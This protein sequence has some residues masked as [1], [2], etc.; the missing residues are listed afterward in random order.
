MPVRASIFFNGHMS[1]QTARCNPGALAR[2]LDRLLRPTSVAVVGISAQP[3]TPG[4]TVLSNLEAAGFSGTLHRVSRGRSEVAGRP[5]VSSIGELPEHVDLA[6]LCLPQNAV[7]QALLDCAQRRVG[8]VVVFASG[9]AERDD[10]G[11]A[12]QDELA[13]IATENQVA[14]LG[15]NCYG[16]HSHAHALPISFSRIAPPKTALARTVAIVSQSGGMGAAMSRN[17]QVQGVGATYMVAT[18]NE[19]TLSVEDFIADFVDDAETRVIAVLAEHLRQPQLLLSAA[20]RARAAGKAI[21][22]LH[23]GRSQNARESALSHTGALAGDHALMRALVS[24]EAVILVD[25]FQE[26]VDVASV[27]A[28]YPKAPTAG[29]GVLTTSGAFRGLTFD[30]CEQLGLD[31]PALAPSTLR[32]LREVLPGFTDAANP[33]DLT[34]Q[35]IWQRDLLGAAAA[36]LL[37]DDGIGSIVIALTAAPGEGSLVNAQL[38][39]PVLRESTKPVLYA[40]MTDLDV[41]H[42]QL[43]PTL[44]E[45]GVPYF[46]SPEAALA[47]I[48]RITAHG[49]ARLRATQRTRS[50]APVPTLPRD[51]TLNEAEAKAWLAQAGIAMPQGGLAADLLQA[52]ALAERIGYPLALKA[53]SRALLHK[54]DAG[55]V[56]LDIRHAEQLSAAWERVAS[57]VQ[58]A[59]PGLV[60]DGMLI[61]RMAPPGVEM[62]VGARRDAHW[63]PVLMVGLGGIWIETLGDVRLMPADLAEA[64]IL[65]EILQLRGAALLQGARG[66]RVAD[67]PALASAAARI[68][69]VMLGTP[70][71]QEI[72]INPLRVLPDGHGVV[73]LD[74]LVVSARRPAHRPS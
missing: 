60:L 19:A 10:E 50:H 73:A 55:G 64:A 31:I 7:K 48:A 29:V 4:L 44:Q 13:R 18:G 39:V 12:E 71:L 22:L 16:Y 61:E 74:A 41:L 37:Q 32:A 28:R 6:V 20:A 59:Q 35:L 51:G 15:P 36:P 14:L 34:T 45:A 47:T 62:V 33:V 11:R 3:G 67:L 54:S 1:Q 40:A 2:P 65:E 24:H 68:G 49:R 21:V 69:A 56:A 17:L 42:P 8:A 53:Q 43:R 5:C 27:M 57:Q 26:W 63:G 30:L 58:R 52:R 66:S 23:P 46:R 9:F 25:S 38:A 70:S 72:E